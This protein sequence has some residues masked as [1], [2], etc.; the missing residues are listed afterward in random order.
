METC[1]INEEMKRESGRASAR[2]SELAADFTAASR[3]ALRPD[4]KLKP[5]TE[6]L[7]LSFLVPF[8]HE[9]AFR[10]ETR[11]VSICRVSLEPRDARLFI[12]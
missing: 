3:P 7:S 6:I 8:K 10:K 1:K 5:A 12:R 11:P 9:T 2:P 4:P